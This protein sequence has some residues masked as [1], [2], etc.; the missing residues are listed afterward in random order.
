MIPRFSYKT[1]EFL[2]LKNVGRVFENR[3]GIFILFTK[4]GQKMLM[5]HDLARSALVV[6]RYAYQRSTRALGDF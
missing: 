4:I 2:S 5:W 6:R 1:L 3:R